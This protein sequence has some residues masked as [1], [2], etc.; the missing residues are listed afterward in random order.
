VK[1]IAFKCLNFREVIVRNGAA[2]F[3]DDQIG[4]ARFLVFFGVI[5]A[6]LTDDEQAGCAV[7]FID[8]LI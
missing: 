8:N 4:S 1:I 2:S 3:F 7:N 5:Y 6:F